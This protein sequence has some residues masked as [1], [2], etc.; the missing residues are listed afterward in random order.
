MELFFDTET[1]GFRNSTKPNESWIVQIA[2]ILSDEERVY[3]SINYLI[4][5]DGRT[6]HPKA[7]ELH[8]ISIEMADKYGMPELFVSG[9]FTLL[10]RHADI[11]VCHNIGFDLP[12]VLDI[13]QR[14]NVKT[15]ILSKRKF[16]TMLESTDICQLPGR[17]SRLFKWPRLEELYN[18]CFDEEL[19][20]AHDA[21]VDVVA[22]RRCYYHLRKNHYID[23]DRKE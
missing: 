20:G 12:F 19:V 4:K 21:M 6:I 11:L 15:N 14:T 10:S 13:L 5:A 2:A 16:C 1:S 9:A 23:G 22:T 18:F 7:E 3:G 8:G 17:S